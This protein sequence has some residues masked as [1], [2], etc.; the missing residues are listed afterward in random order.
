[1]GASINRRQ[2]LVAAGAGAVGTAAALGAAP[3]KAL[4]SEGEDEAGVEGSWY[5][6]VKV[7]SPSP[8]SFDATYGFAKGGVFTR[9]DGRTNAP[10]VGTWKRAKGGGIVFSNL[11][12]NFNAGV[13]PSPASRNGAIVGNFAAHVASDGTLVG[14]FTAH[15]VLGLT[16]FS[17]AGTFTGTRIEAAGP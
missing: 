13:L 2:L 16:G 3:L 6:T 7:T 8:A 11:L 5:I 14:T 1:M 15:G 9:I 17:R 4:A 12:F 10:A